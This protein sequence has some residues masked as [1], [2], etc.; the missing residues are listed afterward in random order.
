MLVTDAMSSVGASSTGRDR[1][2][3]MGR[4]VRLFDGRL[5]TADGTLA[6]AH[7]TMI[8]AVRNAVR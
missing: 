4:E 3:L 2:M 7:L 5:T 8:E 1:F 6:G